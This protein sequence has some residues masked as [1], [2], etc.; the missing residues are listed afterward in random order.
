MS[1]PLRPGKRLP[2]VRHRLKIP[3]PALQPAVPEVVAMQH[4]LLAS[5]QDDRPEQRAPEPDEEAADVEDEVMPITDDMQPLPAVH[6]S[7]DNHLHDVEGEFHFEG[8]GIPAAMFMTQAEQEAHAEAVA[9]RDKLQ[10]QAERKVNKKIGSM[11]TAIVEC[12]DILK[13]TEVSFYLLVLV[14]ELN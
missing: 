11:L 8:E 14:N 7:E 1:D 13:K 5:A 4:A 2:N 3:K 10:R 6:D 9:H 12:I